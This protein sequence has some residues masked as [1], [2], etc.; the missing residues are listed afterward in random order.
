M[1]VLLSHLRASASTTVVVIG[2]HL[3]CVLGVLRLVV[4]LMVVVGVE[5]RRHDG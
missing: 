5:E 4:L 3:G 2:V 1:G